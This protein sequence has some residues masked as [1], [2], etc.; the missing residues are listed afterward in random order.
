MKIGDPVRIV[1]V[2]EK[3][4]IHETGTPRAD[5]DVKT[6]FGRCLGHTFPIVGFANGLI[7]LEV[8]ELFGQRACMH[9]IWIEP[10][11]IVRS[12]SPV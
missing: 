2:P 9:S 4:P 12:E 1:S 5:L 10:D 11:H 7:E 6:I 3:L 8:G